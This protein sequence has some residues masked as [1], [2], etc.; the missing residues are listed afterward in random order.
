MG[1]GF[2]P[3]V[4]DAG[5]C[6]LRKERLRDKPRVRCEFDVC[7]L[8]ASG[9]PGKGVCVSGEG[10]LDERSVR[11]STTRAELESAV[12]NSAFTE[13]HP[14]I[15]G[16]RLSFPSSSC[17]LPVIKFNLSAEVQPAAG[18]C[19]NSNSN[20]TVAPSASTD[21]L[22][23]PA[24]SG[25]VTRLPLELVTHTLNC[26]LDTCSTTLERQAESQRF[27]RICRT[28]HSG[29]LLSEAV[30]ECA[31]TS[32]ESANQLVQRLAEPECV[33]APVL[34]LWM[35]LAFDPSESA[36]VDVVKACAGELVELEYD[37]FRG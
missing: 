14:S 27:L 2:C 1:G 33:L 3:C 30:H 31:V 9:W 34:K 26:L 4:H 28:F 22:D 24:S 13:H 21:N 36:V 20:A 35:N 25:P 29:Y 5:M 8:S 11:A 37:P 23:R 7:G 18:M 15:S 12:N 10:E 17:C 32:V 16:L 6:L 19:F